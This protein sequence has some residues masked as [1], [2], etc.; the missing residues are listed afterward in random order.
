[1]DSNSIST[2]NL[3]LSES[4]ISTSN[5][6]LTNSTT[7]QQQ[8]NILTANSSH[9]SCFICSNTNKLHKVKSNSIALGFLSKKIIIKKDT[10]VCESHLDN[11]GEILIKEF[12]KIKTRMVQYEKTVFNLL[13]CLSHFKN[14]QNENTY[15]FQYFKDLTTLSDELCKKITNW[16]KTEFINFS[17]Y[18]MSLNETESRSKYQ[19]IALYR[20]WLLKGTDQETLSYLFGNVSQQKISNYLDTIRRAIN[21]DFVPFFL[22]A[23]SRKRE[24]F[25][26]RNNKT[27]KSLFNLNDDDL[28][29]VVDGS[30]TRIEKSSNNDFQYSTWSSQKYDSLIKPFIL[31]CCDG[32]IIDCYG[33]F[34]ALSND[35]TILRYI[36][37]SDDELLSILLRDKTC[38]LL[39]RGNKYIS[40]TNIIKMLLYLLFNK[41]SETFIMN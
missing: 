35:A 16:S 40:H 19:L 38:F 31:C 23:A 20:Y 39:D 2:L 28:M 25:C 26:E 30:Y 18:I 21:K 14:D 12:D 27:A 4:S 1:M 41:D 5:N 29:V 33:P 8:Y 32:Y 37:N 3:H 17:R 34:K 13:D 36:L 9:K 7:L 11:S 15:I 6:Q 24:F 10:R 22:G